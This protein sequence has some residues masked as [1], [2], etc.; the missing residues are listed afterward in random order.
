[1]EPA[2]PAPCQ[3]LPWDSDF[4]KAR[5]ARVAGGHMDNARAA[6]VDAWCLSEH[7]NCVYFLTE[8]SDA[9]AILAAEDHGFRLMDIRETYVLSPGKRLPHPVLPGL[10]IRAALPDDLP[11]LE[12]IA[13]YSHRDTRF[14]SDPHFQRG[15]CDELYRTWIR[16]SC[17][18]GFADAVL[19]GDARGQA[20][21]YVSC[22]LDQEPLRGRIGLV[23]VA[24]EWRGS[25]VG[26]ALVA[27]AVGWFRER[28]A[29]EVSVVTQGRNVNGQR[30]Y[31]RCGFLLRAAEAWFH[32]WYAAGD[33]R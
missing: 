4:F 31:Q 15:L 5:I 10:T 21:G 29:S 25:G 11:A 28:A 23:G 32:K 33:R 1:M 19:V 9:Q 12:A 8:L 20:I 2:K 18:E 7:V 16:R 14:Y 17:G 24:E 27:G 13:G 30:L 3:V 22:S 26:P 6:A